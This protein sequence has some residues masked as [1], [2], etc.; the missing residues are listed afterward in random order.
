ML[1]Y[2]VLGL[3]DYTSR[4][5]DGIGARTRLEEPASGQHHQAAAVAAVAAPP[6]VCQ[7]VLSALVPPDATIWP[8][9][10]YFSFSYL[11]LF[12]REREKER[13]S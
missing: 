10:I 8:F 11:L 4:S 5:R 12:T 7:L 2:A 3:V 9:S 13:K 1:G 6:V